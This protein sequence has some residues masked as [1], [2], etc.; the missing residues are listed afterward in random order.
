MADIESLEILFESFVN[1]GAS[2]NPFD[3]PKKLA[4]LQMDGKG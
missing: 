4:S 2:R 3:T 1:F